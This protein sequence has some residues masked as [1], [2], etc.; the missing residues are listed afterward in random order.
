M[1]INTIKYL[2]IP[3]LHKGRDEI[4][5]DCYG[6]IILFYAQE[7]GIIIKDYEY[8]NNWCRQGFNFIQEEYRKQWIKITKPEPY[9]VV[10]FT[11]LGQKVE[12]HL[13]I[14]MHDLIGFLHCPLNNMVSMDKLS[15]PIWKKF[16]TGFY[17]YN[18]A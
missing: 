8:D 4:G 10:G 14:L 12:H 11:M 18:D 2:N 5:L 15:H 17:K 1:R 9:C 16:A 7:F 6:L 3:Y 13:G